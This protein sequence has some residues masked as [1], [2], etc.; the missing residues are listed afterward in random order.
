MRLTCPKCAAQYE[1][2]DK[3]IPVDGRDVKCSNC[4]HTWFQS[5]PAMDRSEAEEQ[6]TDALHAALNG[7]ETEDAPA[8]ETAP[9]TPQVGTP[10][11]PEPAL[12]KRAMDPEVASILKEEAALEAD[13]RARESS[14]LESQP[15]LGLD[16][17]LADG[18]LQRAREARARLAETKSDTHPTETDSPALDFRRG[19]L[20]DIEK[21]NASLRTGGEGKAQNGAVTPGDDSSAKS[22]SGGFAR[23]F[24]GG[25][26]RGFALSLLILAAAILIYGNAP[27]ISNRA[28]QVGNT[29]N[30]YVNGVDKA[31]LWLDTQIDSLLQ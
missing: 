2:P 13:F 4:G 12:A 10:S 31:R 26:A 5:H 19:L 25:F 8:P 29:L 7:D 11:P 14:G 1:V 3:V 9:P 17:A 24:A 27:T 30:S 18:A 16:T 23:G 6:T 20:P 22:R 21:T 15:D 28:P